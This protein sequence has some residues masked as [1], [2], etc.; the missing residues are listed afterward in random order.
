VQ[1]VEQALEIEDVALAKINADNIEDDPE[2]HVY[3]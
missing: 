1:A 3:G 2:V